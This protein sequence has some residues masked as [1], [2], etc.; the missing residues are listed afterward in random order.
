MRIMYVV[1]F[2]HNN[3]HLVNSKYACNSFNLAK[4]FSGHEEI[5]DFFKNEKAYPTDCFRIDPIMTYANI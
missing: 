5:F 3:K 2:P 4:K 1:Y